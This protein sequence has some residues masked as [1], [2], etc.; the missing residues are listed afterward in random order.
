MTQFP[1]RFLSSLA[2]ATL[3]LSLAACGDKEGSNVTAPTGAPVAAVAAPAG[4]TWADTIA[5]TP[6][7]GY[8]MGNPSAAIKVVEF[9]SYTCPHCRDFATE[10]DA[11]MRAFV[12]SGKVSYELRS[13]VRDPLDMAMALL[14]RCSGKDAFFP[15]GIQFFGNQAA[16]F[17]KA[18]AMG[19]AQYQAA[20]SAPPQQ[21]F[22]TLAQATGLIDFAKQRGISEDQAKQCLA[23]TAMAEKLA[24]EVQD[25]TQQYNI[26]GTPTLLLNGVVQENASAWPAMRAKIKEAGA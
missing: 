26:S 11:E 22:I 3:S 7:G 18:Q 5:E 14:V 8:R 17:E 20:V 1:S 25:A 10:S 2:V 23:D 16:M 15:L 6:E 13:Y 19:D 24:K 4:T 21:R 9:A 12:N